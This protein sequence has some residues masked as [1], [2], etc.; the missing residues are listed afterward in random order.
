MKMVFYTSEAA[1]IGKP[2]FKEAQGGKST[3]TTS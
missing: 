2:A 1:E 3:M